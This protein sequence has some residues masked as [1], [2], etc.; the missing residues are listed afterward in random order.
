MKL[1][2]LLLALLAVFHT[3]L[4]FVPASGLRGVFPYMAVSYPSREGMCMEQSGGAKGAKA[5]K[6]PQWF[7]T[8]EARHTRNPKQPRIARRAE[9]VEMVEQPVQPV[10]QIEN[11]HTRKEEAQQQS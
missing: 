11:E 7:M 2:L 3:T 6:M 5:R 10:A 8:K 4:G 9:P 1:P